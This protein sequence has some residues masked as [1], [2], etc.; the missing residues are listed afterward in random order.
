VDAWKRKGILRVVLV[1]I[2]VVD[3]HSPFSIFLFYKDWVCR[4]I[5]MCN[6]SNETSSLE[7]VYLY[8]N[9]LLSILNEAAQSLLDRSS[10]LI[11]IQGVLSLLP[12]HS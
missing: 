3:T 4:P 1:E 6:F 8:R 10:L 12:R 11:K 9:G 7:L 2:G 5:W